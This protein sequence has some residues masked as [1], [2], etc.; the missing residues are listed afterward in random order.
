MDARVV[1][2]EDWRSAVGPLVRAFWDYAETVHLLPD[3][4][5]RHRVLPRYLGA[6]C[7]DAARHGG[8]VVADAGGDV[9]GACVWLPPGAY[10]LATARQLR[11]L[12]RLVPALPWAG[13]AL[14]EARRAGRV[15][16]SRHPH[17]P[18]CWVRTLG[19]DPQQQRSGVGRSLMAPVLGR[20]DADG[21][22]CY[23]TTAERVNVAYYERLGFVVRDEY[24]PTPTWPTVW[25]MWRPPACAD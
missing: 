24:A 17:E 5:R 12:P 11:D 9:V 18:H 19:V 20:A 7:A 14:A 21:V 15:H 16:R 4:R 6:E 23:L 10:P 8:L 13:A 25:S 22:G 3:A 1:A 2:P